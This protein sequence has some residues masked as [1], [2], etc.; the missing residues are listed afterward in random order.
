M[1]SSAVHERG[2]VD[3]KPLVVSGYAV[4]C[5]VRTIPAIMAEQLELYF[6]KVDLL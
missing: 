1:L 6:N 5:L 3:I 4:V 2:L